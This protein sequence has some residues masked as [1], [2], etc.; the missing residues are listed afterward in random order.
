MVVLLATAFAVIS[1]AILRV[2]QREAQVDRTYKA[3]EGSLDLGVSD[4]LGPR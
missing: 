1:P 2:R 4:T 3:R